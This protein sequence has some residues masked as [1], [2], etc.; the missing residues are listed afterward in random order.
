M[1]IS[2]A[3]DELTTTDPRDEIEHLEARIEQLAAKIEGCRKFAL[4]ARVAMA[5]GGVVLAAMLLRA[6]A[7]DPTAL[8]AAIG[9]LLGGI[10]LLGSNATTAREAADQLREAEA[11]RAALIG[12]IGLRLVVDRPTLH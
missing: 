7:P 6:F 10:V 11:E 1:V 2:L 4:A 12:S 5:L 8:I 3:M 9:A